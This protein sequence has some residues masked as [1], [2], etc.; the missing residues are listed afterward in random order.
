V[1]ALN[2]QPAAPSSKAVRTL[3]AILVLVLLVGTATAGA[4]HVRIQTRHHGP[5]H[6][7]IPRGYDPDHA[8]VVVFVHGYFASVDAAW[9]HYHLARQF[10]ASHLNAMFIACEA[11][12]G[13]QDDV[14]WPS[15]SDLLAR[16]N[17]E[18]TLEVPDGPVIAVGHS[19]A[20]RTLATWLEE[21]SLQTIVLLDALYGKVDLFDAWLRASPDHRL[22]DVSEDTR[23]WA[24]QLH[25]A[26]PETLVYNGVRRLRRSALKTARHARIVHVRARIGHMPLVTSGIALPRVL[27]TVRL[28][29]VT[30]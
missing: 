25:A 7:Y 9:Q 13:P 21:P 12:V 14:S 5:I 18:P 17:A 23:P 20:H 22:I 27:R 19:A 15:L 26:F 16:V 8:G 3:L 29:R 10:A 2:K 30:R 11:P 28:Q 4:R 24:R 1:A 6:V